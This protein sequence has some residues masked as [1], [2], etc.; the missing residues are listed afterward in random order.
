MKSHIRPS[1]RDFYFKSFEIGVQ[2]QADVFWPGEPTIILRERLPV[3]R[4][5]NEVSR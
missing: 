3:K 1:P 4:S 5:P 2:I